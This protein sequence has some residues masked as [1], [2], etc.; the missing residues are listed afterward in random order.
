[1]F[2]YNRDGGAEAVRLYGCEQRRLHTYE[3]EPHLYT[4]SVGIG[5]NESDSLTKDDDVVQ[6]LYGII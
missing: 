3:S 1:M 4:C 2:E 5:L 6:S